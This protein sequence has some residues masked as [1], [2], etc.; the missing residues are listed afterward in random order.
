[1][2]L[3]ESLPPREAEKPRTTPPPVWGAVKGRDGGFCTSTGPTAPDLPSAFTRRGPRRPRRTSAGSVGDGQVGLVC[4]AVKAYE[5]R[6]TLDDYRTFQ[7]LERGLVEVTGRPLA[8]DLTK[9]IA[10]LVVHWPAV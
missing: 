3:R 2:T 5:A 4:D 7:R 8:R 9:V 6:S 1:M 10:R